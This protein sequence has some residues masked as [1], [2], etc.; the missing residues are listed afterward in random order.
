M[1]DNYHPER[2]IP[3]AV[4]SAVAVLF[5]VIAWLGLQAHRAADQQDEAPAA[6]PPDAAFLQEIAECRRRGGV[7]FERV[8]DDPREPRIAICLGGSNRARLSHP[9][10]AIQ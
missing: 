5:A 1:T 4:L 3:L 6:L 9:L 10:Q 7:P 8:A 2:S